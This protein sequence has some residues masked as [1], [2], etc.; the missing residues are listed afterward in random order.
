MRLLQILSR[1][2]NPFDDCKIY[3]VFVRVVKTS[4]ITYFWSKKGALH[5]ANRKQ[6][7]HFIEIQNIITRKTEVIRN[8]NSTN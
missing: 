1:I 8:C 2:C 6:S 7:A 4:R 3:I 5:F